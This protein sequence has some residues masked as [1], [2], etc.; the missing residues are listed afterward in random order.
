[1]DI[2]VKEIAY[3]LDAFLPQF[4]HR[5]AGTGSAAHMQEKPHK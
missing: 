2:G 4:L 5:I 3:R 1:V